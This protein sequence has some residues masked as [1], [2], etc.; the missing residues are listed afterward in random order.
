MTPL[1]LINVLEEKLPIVLAVVLTEKG[2]SPREKVITEV[3]SEF[4]FDIE[5][6]T[7]IKVIEDF[8]DCNPIASFLER[9]NKLVGEMTTEVDKISQKL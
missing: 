3:A 9:I 1:D 8:F 4:E 7:I 2:F 5:L 6:E